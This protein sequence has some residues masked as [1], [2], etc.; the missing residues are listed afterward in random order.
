MKG[1]KGPMSESSSQE[2]FFEMFSFYKKRN[3]FFKILFERASMSWGAEGGGAADSPLSRR[4]YTGLN[5]R[6]LRA[7]PEPKADT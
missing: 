2:M 7:Q 1:R 3:C 4:P 6:T 5:P